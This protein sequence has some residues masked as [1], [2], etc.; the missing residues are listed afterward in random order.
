MKETPASPTPCCRRWPPCRSSTRTWSA[1]CDPGPSRGWPRPWTRCA[2]WLPA[3]ARAPCKTRATPCSRPAVR[4]ASRPGR[5]RMTWTSGRSWLAACWGWCSVCRAPVW[6][7]L[8]LRTRGS[9]SATS[10]RCSG[11]MASQACAGTNKTRMRC[12]FCSSPRSPATRMTRRTRTLPRWCNAPK[13]RRL[14]GRCGVWPTLRSCSRPQA[15]VSSWHRRRVPQR[16]GARE[17]W[18]RRHRQRQPRR[19]KLPGPLGSCSPLCRCGPPRW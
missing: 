17:S 10:T 13:A 6:R 1:L 7:R 9:W 2:S 18:F 11:G 4:P 3:P 14:A 5:K 8:L 12:C 19:A 16:P 15:A